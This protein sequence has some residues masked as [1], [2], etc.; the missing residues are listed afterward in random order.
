MP[1][2]GLPLARAN[3]LGEPGLLQTEF[4]YAF[5]HTRR[6]K[7]RITAF[8]AQALGLMGPAR[9]SDPVAGSVAELDITLNPARFALDPE[10]PAEQIKSR[11]L[12]TVASA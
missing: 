7:P 12:D 10:R 11:R 9:L 5:K 4:G 2:P 3:V 1:P 6:G 8:D